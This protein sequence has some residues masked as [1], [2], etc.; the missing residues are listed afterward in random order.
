MKS[1]IIPVAVGIGILLVVAALLHTLAQ[2]APGGGPPDW[3][4]F[5]GMMGP[6]WPPAPAAV[7]VVED[8][9]VYVACDGTL[10]AFG[11]KTLEPLGEAIYW[12]RPELPQ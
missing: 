2:P 4:G 7:V 8:G 11:A 9:V 12:E 1:R 3:G 5:P 6:G 10:K